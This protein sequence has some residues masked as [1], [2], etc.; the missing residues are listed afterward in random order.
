MHD[1]PPSP[2]FLRIFM[3]PTSV[4]ASATWS[5]RPSSSPSSTACPGWR[6]R[7]AG[8]LA[9]GLAAAP[10]CIVWDFIARRTGE[11]NAL[12]LAAVLQIVGILLP[13]VAVAAWGRSPAPCSS[14]APSSAW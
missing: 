10:A 1:N 6:A 4:P 8:F 14:A 7:A 9:I 13:V 2:L 11:L 3:A 5:A 12:I